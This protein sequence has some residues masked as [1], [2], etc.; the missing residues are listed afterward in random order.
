MKTSKTY[1]GSTLPTSKE[2]LTV[3]LQPDIKDALK[4]MS[5]EQKRSM[6]FLAE[7]AINEMVKQ[8]QQNNK[9]GQ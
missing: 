9:T 6:A 5:E 7:E 8:W 2:S 3:Y 4:Q 1:T